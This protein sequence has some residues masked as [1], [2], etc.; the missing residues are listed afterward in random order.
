MKWLV[1]FF[2]GAGWLYAQGSESLLDKLP[3]GIRV[4]LVSTPP[5]SIDRECNLTITQNSQVLVRQS[6][7]T[8]QPIHRSDLDGDGYE[9]LVFSGFSGGAHCCFDLTIVS[10]RPHAPAPYHL[11]MANAEYITF[12]DLDGDKKPEIITRDD[13]YSY[14]LGLCFACSAG[15]R[16]VTHYDGHTQRG[17]ASYLYG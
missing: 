7:Y 2:L 13:Q 16:V 14:G 17:L 9:E 6:N 8:I 4:D 5:S 10:L 3:Y 11:E 15:V 12:K 1:I